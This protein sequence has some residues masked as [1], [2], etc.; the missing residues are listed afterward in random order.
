MKKKFLS[1]FTILLIIIVGVAF[2]A[3]SDYETPSDGS[4]EDSSRSFTHTITNG[5]FYNASTSS[6]DDKGDKAVLDAVASWTQSSG[7]T[8]VS[9]TGDKGVLAAAVDLSDATMFNS[10]ASKY[11]TVK[12]DDEGED[13]ANPLTMTYPGLDEANIPMVDKLDADGKV[14]YGA[15]GKAE[16]VKEDTNA[17][18]IASTTTEGSVYVKGSSAYTL[19]KDSYYMLQFSVCTMIDA[20]TSDADFAN[21]GAWFVVKGDV[22]YVVPCIN[23]NNA[24]KTYY[25]FVETNKYNSM[26]INV[27][28]WLGFGPGHSTSSSYQADGKDLYATRG[29]AL[30]DNVICEKVDVEDMTTATQGNVVEFEQG[31]SYNAEKSNHANFLNMK[32]AIK[33][34]KDVNGN[35]YVKASSAYYLTNASMELR[36]H[37]TS[38]TTNSY[39]KY[40]Y[41]YR[42][43]YASNNLKDWT[44]T[45]SESSLDKRYYG[46]VDLSKLY[47]VSSEEDTSAVKDNY[48]TLIG[49]SYKFNAVSYGDWYNK[50]MRT[51]AH[52][53]TAADETYALMLY[54]KDLQANTLKSSDKIIIEPNTYYEISVWAYVWAKTYDGDFTYFADFS[55]TAPV[56]PKTKFTTDET[57]QYTLYE[58]TL[59]SDYYADLDDA[60]KALAAAFDP[61][62]LGDYVYGNS[63]AESLKTD[64]IA[65]LRGL[66]NID[67]TVNIDS[68]VGNYYYAYLWSIKDS[69][70]ANLTALESA[71]EKAYYAERQ[72]NWETVSGLIKK[73]DEYNEDVEEY[74]IKKAEYDSKYQIWENNPDNAN[75]PFATISLT[76]AGDGFEKNTTALNEWQKITLYVQGNQL[77][78]RQL[79]LEL[80]LGTGSDYS[81]YMIGGAYFDN[82]EIVAYETE[83]EAPTGI[84]W[85]ILSEITATEQIAFG[86]LYGTGE[87]NADSQAAIDIVN[88]NWEIATATGTASTDIT[89]VKATVASSDVGNIDVAGNDYNLYAITLNNEIPTASTLTYVGN[90]KFAI[91]PNKFYRIAM[92][93]KTEGIKE[94]LGIKIKLLKSDNAAE[95]GDTLN[96]AV[97]TYSNESE[98][99]AEVVYYV[100][101][102]LLDTYYV[103][104]QVVMGEGTRFTTEKYVQGKVMISAI[105]CLEIDYK[106]YNEAATGDKITKNVSLY[107]VSYD[108]DSSSNSFGNSY[109]S[110]LDYEKTDKEEFSE[111]GKLTGI[112]ATDDWTVTDGTKAIYNTYSIPGSVSIDNNKRLTFNGSTG[113]SGTTAIEEIAPL[114]YE[115]WIK[116]TEDGES[117]EK[118]FDIV[119]ATADNEEYSYDLE[120]SVGESDVWGLTYFA[121]KAVGKDGI[122]SLSAYTATALGTNN[123]T[124]VPAVR[125]TEKAAKAQAGTIVVANQADSLFGAVDG[126]N[127]VSP[128][129]TLMKIT[130]SYATV[131]SAYSGSESLSSDKYYKISVWVRT[132]VG[133]YASISI[134]GASGSL[135]ANTNS[136]ELGFVYVTTNGQWQ[137]YCLFVETSNFDASLYVKLSLG[138]PYATQKSGKVGSSSD[139]NTYYST[140]DLSKGSVYFDAVKI[141]EITE[142]EFADAKDADENKGDATYAS[143]NHEY[144]YTTIPYY[145]YI[146]EYVLDSFDAYDES[147]SAE[148]GHEPTNYSRSYDSD[149]TKDNTLATYGIYDKDSDSEN[150]VSA[151]EYLYKYLDKEDESVYVYNKIFKDLF[152]SNFDCAEW[153]DDEWGTFMD[154]FLTIDRKDANG[155]VVYEGG[156]NVLVMSNKAESGY[157]QSYALDSSYNGTIQAGEYAKITFTART[158]LARVTAT[159]TKENDKDVTTYSYN[160]DEAFA[161]MKIAPIVKGDDEINVKINSQVYG[162]GGIYDAV[163]YTVY[164]Y[165]KSAESN[166]VNWSFRL[167]DE[168][169]SKEDAT[170]F[171]KYLV[172]LLAVDLVSMEKIEESEYTAAKTAQGDTS[173]FYEYEEEKEEEKKDEEEEETPEETEDEDFWTKLVNNEYF[174]LYI[175]SFVIALAIIITVVVVVINKWK[176]RHPKQVVGENT[177]KTEKDIK[178]VLPEVQ[179]KEEAEEDEEYVDEIKPRYVQRTVNK[180][181]KKKKK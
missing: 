122:S 120:Q 8:T 34:T 103:G 12:V 26:S 98:D 33:S 11:L 3:C 100:S 155:N 159:T 92:L 50:I 149:L 125:T 148:I 93:V 32:S 170:V 59:I 152:G 14:V 30:F 130:S 163:T 179:V 140:A 167:G 81:T 181:K 54:N 168:P 113:Y 138:N 94:G 88:N 169:N 180:G 162:E 1:I 109:Y 49:D 160:T 119:N 75:G 150:M 63:A 52:N 106:E 77:S 40:F 90:N 147:T 143:A 22:E 72:K 70:N 156:N 28:L 87:L 99:W 145:I 78:S 132:D 96:E 97:S 131:L 157:A 175:S 20:A 55:T 166:E 47:N 38:Y 43:N 153:G 107:N 144:V 142:N 13:L 136:S 42:E 36:S 7:S 91:A 23:T 69:W 6:T 57:Y 171:E 82:V 158:L 128:Y 95:E 146:M 73:I 44:L 62:E 174:W 102:D 68:L 61:A 133:T 126:I 56:D 89:S 21:K 24:W 116:Y 178:V 127:Y 164:L 19:A 154:E 18:V 117:V 134:D 86:G 51:A 151:I 108:I 27:E 177:V 4:E 48:S 83:E 65:W 80:A 64:A 135:Q 112:G 85:N 53:L 29:V 46:S 41:T 74:E 35:A 172:G 58:D 37:V 84:D 141:T 104:L 105:N 118:L 165:N 114:Y 76:G 139:T 79:T 129:P 45:T 16:K 137:E 123:G 15:D 31:Y 5:T 161:R 10:F 25:L 2:V 71:I 115:I 17:L 39:R 60:Q 173:Y 66:L 67:S 101:G 111:D 9:K 176:K 124:V 121:V 110:K